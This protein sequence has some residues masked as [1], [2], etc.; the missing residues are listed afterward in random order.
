M[1]SFLVCSFFDASFDVMAS[2]RVEDHAG[3]HDVPQGGVG[4]AV[5]PAVE[6][7]SFLFAAAGVDWRYAAQVSEGGLAF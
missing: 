6:P 7:V 3:E 4:L 2:A 1:A 5:A